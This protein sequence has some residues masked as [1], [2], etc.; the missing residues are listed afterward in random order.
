M[1]RAFFALL[2]GLRLTACGDGNPFNGGTNTSQQT[3]EIFGTSIEG[4]TDSLVMNGL[5]YND[6]GTADPNDDTLFVN[7]LPF[8]NSD[9]SGGGYTL[10]RTLTNGFSVYESP[11]VGA[12]GEN[13]YFAVFQRSNFAQVAA[14]GTGDFLEAGFGGL[15]AQRLQ[16]S[17]L[18]APRATSYT[19][20]G[21]YAAVRVTQLSGGRGDIEFITGD[22]RMR[23]DILDFDG[24]G[25]VGGVINNRQLFDSFGN[26]LGTL[27]DF[28]SLATTDVNF[29]NAS[30]NEGDAFGQEGTVQLGTGRW[31][32]IFAGPNGEEI[33]GIVVVDG[34]LPSGEPVDSVRE[35]GA[36]IVVNGG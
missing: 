5:T 6:Q 12:P 11:Q 15:T 30:I 24:T 32:G 27:N 3:S 23:V 16:D 9:S 31:S 20:T 17:S 18:P 19:F 34:I 22:A 13:L 21:D 8:D 7:N 29:D 10:T 28:V 26:P 4:F 2:A 14:V 36:F 35:L 25:A 1:V 33:A